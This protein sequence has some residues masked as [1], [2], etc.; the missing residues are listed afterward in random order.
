MLDS[1]KGSVYVSSVYLGYSEN[2]KNEDEI[3]AAADLLSS[4]HDI[5]QACSRSAEGQDD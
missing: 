3:K 1:R 4:Q 5:V 2:S